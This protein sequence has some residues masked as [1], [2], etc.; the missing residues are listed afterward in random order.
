MY[1]RSASM[2][3]THCMMSSTPSGVSSRKFSALGQVLGSSPIEWR[4]VLCRSII[5]N[6]KLPHSKPAERRR[7]SLE[8]VRIG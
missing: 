3:D 6:A 4:F 1:A 8:V 7:E 5:A 2:P